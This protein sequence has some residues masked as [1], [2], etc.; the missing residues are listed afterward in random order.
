MPLQGPLGPP[1]PCSPLQ[2]ER[3]PG[4]F[5]LFVLCLGS[6][7]LLGRGAAGWAHPRG[8]VLCTLVL[9]CPCC[10][11]RGAGES[12]EHSTQ[13][14][15]SSSSIPPQW[16]GATWAPY[17]RAVATS[18][19][20][21][22]LETPSN[23]TFLLH[24]PCTRLCSRMELLIPHPHPPPDTLDSAPVLKC[25]P[26]HKNTPGCGG[27]VPGPGTQHKRGRWAEH[28][29]LGHSLPTLRRAL[30]NATAILPCCTH[31]WPLC[32]CTP[33]AHSILLALS[34]WVPRCQHRGWE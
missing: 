10:P 13:L 4:L 11:P 12:W 9:F 28:P 19:H 18:A 6:P 34:C 15:G 14:M 17:P 5:A 31:S 1:G 16:S 8:Q 3:A 30:A 24:P 21:Q 26:W 25:P 23:P 33:R 32:P 22:H 20:T 27:T 29:L 7:T 2:Q